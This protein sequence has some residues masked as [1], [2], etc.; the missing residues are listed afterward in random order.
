MGLRDAT[1]YD[2]IRRNA[3]VHPHKDCIVFKDIRLSHREFKDR[4]DRLAAGLTQA[5]ISKGDR[6]GIVAYNCDEFMVLY[7]AAAKIGAILLP[8]NWRFQAAEVEF[9]LNDC[10]PRFV[11]AGPD[12]RPMVA[13]MTPR[14][15]SVER[16]YAIGGGTAG[17]GF[18]PFAELYSEKGGH[19]ETDLPADSGYRYV[20]PMAL[21]LEH[22]GG[23]STVTPWTIDYRPYN[24]PERN[25]FFRGRA[26]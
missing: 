21:T 7:G 8:V 18:R 2:F 10:S 4:C 22:G 19:E 20:V 6:L 12:F 9:V 1:I 5:G 25:G 17:D 14:L 24:D 23:Q 26:A 15:K 16:C 3:Q 13:Q 11:F